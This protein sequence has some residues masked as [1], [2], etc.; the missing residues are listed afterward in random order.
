MGR[1][2][3]VTRESSSVVGMR[4]YVGIDHTCMNVCT[5]HGDRGVG[6]ANISGFSNRKGC[7]VLQ[8]RLAV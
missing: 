7:F 2:T 1:E 4:K 5:T 3:Q 6:D 8:S